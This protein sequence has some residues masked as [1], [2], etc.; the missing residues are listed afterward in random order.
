MSASKEKARATLQ[1]LK[2]F[3][4]ETRTCQILFR[5]G[6]TGTRSRHRNRCVIFNNAGLIWEADPRHAELSVAELASGGAPTGESWWSETNRVT[7]LR[8]T[9]ARWAESLPR[10]CERLTRKRHT[11]NRIRLQGRAFGRA[12]R[13]DLTRLNRIGRYLLHAPRAVCNFTLQDEDDV[14]TIDGISDADAA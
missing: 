5:K 10:P 2:K 7:R 4:G 13:A 3:V 6:E 11:R 12:T 14:A 1:D 8:G 9:G